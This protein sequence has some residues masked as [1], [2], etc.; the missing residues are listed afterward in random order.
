[1]SAGRIVWMCWCG[2]WAAVW[3]T[4]AGLAAPHRVCTE[5]LLLGSRCLAWGHAGSWPAVLILAWLS[6]C[7][8]VAMAAP[9]RWGGKR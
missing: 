3:A 1:V 6:A 4:G 2:I 9:L 7:S 5:P 8:V